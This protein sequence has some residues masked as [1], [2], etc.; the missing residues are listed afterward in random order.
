M[1]LETTLEQWRKARFEYGQHD[2]MMAIG[3]YIDTFTGRNSVSEF[4]GT[5]NDAEG[6]Q[7]IIER[8]GSMI[9]LIDYTGATPVHVDNL[10][11]GDVVIVAFKNTEVAGLYLG[12]TVGFVTE[13]GMIEINTRFMKF[14]AGWTVSK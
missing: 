12:D 9:A 10:Q 2:C 5:Y 3:E 11:Q 6:A 4:K 8:H 7:R 13:R 14:I 1:T